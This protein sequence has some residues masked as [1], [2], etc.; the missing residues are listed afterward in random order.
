VE[1]ASPDPA[2]PSPPGSCPR[3]VVTEDGPRPLREL[4]SVY[5]QVRASSFAP[6]VPPACHK[7]R[8]RAVCSGQSRSLETTVALGSGSLTWG[9]GGGRNCMACKGSMLWGVVLD[10]TRRLCQAAQR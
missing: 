9:G 5:L 3:G 2:A 7:Q 6:A 10:I 4:G 8:S 1:F